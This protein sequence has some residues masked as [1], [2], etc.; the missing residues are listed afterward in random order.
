MS[1]LRL[2]PV[3]PYAALA[4]KLR[5]VDGDLVT[6]QSTA[7]AFLAK[8]GRDTFQPKQQLAAWASTKDF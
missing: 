6:S 4:E 3:P 7:D 2:S 1:L 8:D 5:A